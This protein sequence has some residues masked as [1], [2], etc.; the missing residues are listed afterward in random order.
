MLHAIGLPL[1][2]TTGRYICTVAGTH[3]DVVVV[4]GGASIWHQ[5]VCM[6]AGCH[7][8]VATMG[9]L[10]D[11]VQAG[12]ISLKLCRFL[13]SVSHKNPLPVNKGL[14]VRQVFRACVCLLPW[15]GL[16]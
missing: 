9:R 12:V 6:M 2:A 4:Y 7:V 13:P 5:L 3:I 1:F 14:S 15:S 11:F 10:M 16:K 8:I